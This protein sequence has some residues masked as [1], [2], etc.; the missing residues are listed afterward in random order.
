[1]NYL[2][3]ASFGSVMAYI[4]YILLAILVL[5]VMITVHEFGHYVSGKALG[6]GIEEFAIGFGPK[7]YSKKRK[8]GEI[9]SIRAFPLGGFCAFHGEDEDSDDERA[10]NNKSPWRRIIVLI[11]GALMN[12]LLAVLVISAMF[13]I[14]GQSSLI[15]VKTRP[16]NEI[17]EE[18]LLQDYDVILQADG[19]NVYILTDL[20]KA[21]EDKAK[22]EK[23]KFTVYRNGEVVETEVEMR[24][25]TSFTNMEDVQKLYDALGFYYELDGD[26]NLINSGLYSTSVRLGFFRTIGRSF[27]YSFKLAGTIFTILGELLTGKLGISSMG[28]TVTTIG[29]TADAIKVGGF[30]YLLNITAFIGVNLAVFNLL[31]F[32]ALDGSR[33]V[34]SLIEWIFRKPVNRKVE[35]IIHTVGFILLLLFAVFVDLQRCF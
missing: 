17:K 21:V 20:M 4:G 22:G 27:D 12:Y 1:M 16:S 18:Y 3:L 24:T 8:S 19:K 35:G 2:L 10:F 14:Y 32:P 34:F 13:G 30:R 11:S 7:L 5:L 29:V 15:S 23:V 33:V 26:G 28:G 25:D 31:P 9:F 6:F